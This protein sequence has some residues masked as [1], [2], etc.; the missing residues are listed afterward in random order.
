MDFKEVLESYTPEELRA[1]VDKSL[2]QAG[3]MLE[4][5]DTETIS[6]GLNTPPSEYWEPLI[7]YLEGINHE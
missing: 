2:E 6:F 1:F 4:T 3:V 7:S 5:K